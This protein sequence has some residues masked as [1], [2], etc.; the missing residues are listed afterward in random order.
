MP[1][2][3]SGVAVD[4]AAGLRRLFGAQ[5]GQVVAFVSGR[6]ACG[7]TTL[8]ART[9]AALAQAGQ[10]VILIDENSGPHNA[11]S[12]FGIK[13]RHDLLDLVQGDYPL[14]RVMQ[15]AAPL[16]NIIAAAKFAAGPVLLNASAAGRLDAALKRLQD[17]SAFV[18]VDC[19]A[20]NGRQLSPLALAVPY[21]VVV[22]A[23]QSSAITQAYA[24]IKRLAR[25]RGR[26]G[27]HVA[28]TR[29][30]NE[31]EAEAI[32]RNMRH[33][34]R[35][36]L[37]VH[38]GYLGGVRIPATEHLADALQSRLLL[39][40]GSRDWQGLKPS[41]RSTAPVAAGGQRVPR[42]LESMV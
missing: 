2:S 15:P 18:L 22:V 41:A 38:L 26:E 4:Q 14:E 8:L 9:A 16:L 32:F 24:L 7:R 17:G 28:V 12:T 42:P 39:A 33:T 20:R 40:A 11:L 29:A 21:M 10:G 30:R 31:R 19:A 1:E 3:I 5:T 34:A 27:F 35:E 13:A 36:H 25:E 6:E 37:G 23:A